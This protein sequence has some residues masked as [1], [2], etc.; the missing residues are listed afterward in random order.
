M[1]GRHL[2][3][4]HFNTISVF[5]ALWHPT[6]MHYPHLLQ[7]SFV[8]EY[9][10]P[11]ISSGGFKRHTVDEI[12]KKTV[13]GCHTNEHLMTLPRIQHRGREMKRIT[14]GHYTMRDNVPLSA[15]EGNLLPNNVTGRSTSAAWL[16]QILWTLSFCDGP[17]LSQRG[18]FKGIWTNH[19]AEDAP[20]T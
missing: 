4:I 13:A 5:I 1:E 3:R 8:L 19:A 15:I 6:L 16:V 2:S 11:Y 12:S 14:I 7:R 18:R 17:P 9:P 20:A 10:A